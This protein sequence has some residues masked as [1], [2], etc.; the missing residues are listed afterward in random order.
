M[1][2]NRFSLFITCL[3][4]LMLV[5]SLASFASEG[6]PS[7]EPSIIV[8]TSEDLLSP[9]ADLSDG[10]Y[11]PIEITD[12][13]FLAWV[14]LMPL[15]DFAHHTVYILVAANGEVR[16]EKGWWPPELDGEIIL[17]GDEPSYVEFPMTLLT[18]EDFLKI[19]AYPEALNSK[20]ELLDG[21]NPI[22]ITDTTLLYWIDP[23]PDADFC[24][25]LYIFWFPQRAWSESNT[26][27]G[28]LRSMAR[29][30]SMQNHQLISRHRLKIYLN[31][32]MAAAKKMMTIE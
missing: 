27:T 11:T 14:D 29:E 7:F 23:D 2:R 4:A 26:V 16:V 20:D 17:Y 28:G 31:H 8:Y 22:V 32:P 30:F 5:W 9:G 18:E 3:T 10:G 6:K 13:T 19:Y 15:A 24:T 1:I 25:H 21:D 12:L